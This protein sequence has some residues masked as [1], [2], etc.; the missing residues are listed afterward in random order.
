MIHLFETLIFTIASCY[1]SIDLY[2]G[3]YICAL[4][5]LL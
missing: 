3:R 5:N 4:N 1:S 2:K